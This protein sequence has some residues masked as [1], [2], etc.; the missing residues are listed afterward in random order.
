[1]SEIIYSFP[2][3]LTPLPLI[4]LTTEEIA[5]CTNEA[6]ESAKTVP[7]NPPSC[8]FISC[9]T[10]SV[11]PSIDTPKSS[12]NLIILI[13]SFISSIEINKLNPFPAVIAPFTLIF[14]SNLFIKGKLFTNQDTLSLA[15]GLATIVSVFFP[16]L[17]NQEPKD[18]PDGIILD[19]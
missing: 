14:L 6:D 3:P 7:R 19:V 13:I 8:F 9:F 12:N 16:K 2:A 15:K 11:T 18:P 17:A 5:G 4:P 10:V 1:M